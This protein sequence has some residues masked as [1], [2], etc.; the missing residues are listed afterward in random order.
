MIL[1]EGCPGC[2]RR[3]GTKEGQCSRCK[4]CLSCC[5]DKEVQYSCAYQFTEKTARDPR[6]ASRSNKAYERWASNH[7]ILGHNRRIV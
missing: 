2:N 4:R 1:A 6:H 7:R 5:D 3:W